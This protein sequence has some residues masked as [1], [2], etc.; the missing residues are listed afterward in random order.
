MKRTFCDQCTGEITEANKAWDGNSVEG[1]GAPFIE[2]RIDFGRPD[3]DRLHQYLGDFCKFC[4]LETIARLDDR[5][6]GTVIDIRP[7]PN[8]TFVSVEEGGPWV[9]FTP[10]TVKG[11]P[12]KVHAI[13]FENGLVWDAF[14]GWRTS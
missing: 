10:G 11:R 9:P 5:P 6:R 4:V 14:N 3:P 1:E 13:Q 12:N 7:R 2:F 8:T